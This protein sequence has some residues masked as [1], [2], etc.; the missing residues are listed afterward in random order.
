M[1]LWRGAYGFKLQL[2]TALRKKMCDKVSVWITIVAR[3]TEA[4]AAAAATAKC[5]LVLHHATLSH[6]VC[7]FCISLCQTN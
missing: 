1:C 6:P 3:D 7:Y 2:I 5:T 4:A